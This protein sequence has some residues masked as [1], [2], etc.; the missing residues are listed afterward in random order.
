MTV[1][2]LRG[3]ALEAGI[4]PEAF[5]QAVREA[6]QAA[7]VTFPTPLSP[8]RQRIVTNLAA[9]GAFWVTLVVLVRDCRAFGVGWDLRSLADI[10]A[11]TAG[12]MV[13]ERWGARV[14]RV[15]LIGVAAAQVAEFVLHLIFGVRSVQSGPTHFAVLAAGLLGSVTIA[16]ASRPRPDS[17]RSGDL[18]TAAPLATTASVATPSPEG[19]DADRPHRM[20]ARLFLPRA[21]AI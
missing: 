15:L 21:R 16:F 8:L 19:L 20:Q 14:A 1:E 17:G 9:G 13:A 2:E 10:L 11:L 6:R 7:R 18:P 3:A 4:A 5:D 12:I